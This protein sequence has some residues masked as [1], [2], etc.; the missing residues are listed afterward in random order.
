MEGLFQ[1]SLEIRIGGEKED[2]GGKGVNEK[3]KKTNGQRRM[4]YFRLRK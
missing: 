2:E 4:G 3:M 1:P